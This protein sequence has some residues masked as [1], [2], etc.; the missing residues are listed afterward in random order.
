MDILLV[1]GNGRVA[2][3]IIDKLSKENH[4]IYVLTGTKEKEKKNKK[5]FEQYEFEYDN[6]CIKE[7]FVSVNPD[8]TI[9][10]G[11][12]DP[13]F[14]WKN[15]RSESTRYSTAIM[16]VLMAFSLLKH[17]RFI[18]LSSEE[19]YSSSYE[20][21]I[22]EAERGNA[23]SF[24][25]MAILQ[26]ENQCIDYS[27]MMG[28]DTMVLRIDNLCCMPEK[29]SDSFNLINKMCFDA[30][31]SGT[32]SANKNS[33]FSVIYLTDAVEAI[34]YAIIAKEHKKSLYNISSSEEIDEFSVAELISKQIK[35]EV[36]IVNNSIGEKHRIVLSNR[37]FVDEF[38]LQIHNS[39]EDIINKTLTYMKTN[40]K[41]Y[42]NESNSN[43]D[44]SKELVSKFSVI[45]NA[46]IP[47]ME[48][49]VCFIP[50]FML[51]N[52]AVGSQFFAKFDFYLL[53][54]LLFATIYGQ[55]QAAFSALLA[56]AGYCFR[57][58]YTRTS[59]EVV[60]DYNT[61][62]W[63]AQL[64]IV[65]LIVGYLRDKIKSIKNESQIE[66]NYLK[67]QMKDIEDINNSNIKIKNV[68][69][70]QIVN[71]HDSFG[72]IYDITSSLDKYEEG[73][74]LFYAAE[75][76]SKLMNSKDIA[77]Y[78]VANDDYARLI[79][80]TS[81]K[82]KQLGN[83]I[84]YTDFK[85]MYEA[86]MEKKVYINKRMDSIYPLMANAI[87][88]DDNKMKMI[89]MV[90]GIP[91]ER[92][93]LSQAN[94]F[95]VIGLLIRS[96]VIRSNKY[97]EA[98]KSTRYINGTKVLE[99]Q[100]FS[101]LAKTYFNARN[102][103]LTECAIIKVKCSQDDYIKHS[104]PIMKMLRQTDYMGSIDKKNLYV[105]LS[106]TNNE[107]A[108]YVINRFKNAGYESELLEE[109]VS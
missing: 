11:A 67:S 4:R 39:A 20:A 79:S 27:E 19:V 82:A 49:M 42:I 75:V 7:V 6:Q 90:W 63:I 100:A 78:I 72:K 30:F 10:L 109:I 84:K 36:N 89:F 101:D 80:S 32:I 28:R 5:V 45:I 17:G 47:F 26:G 96:A 105:L 52:R 77:I 48:N 102:K 43:I 98:F 23:V 18:Y 16:N 15:S 85:E 99:P 74:V 22:I 51:N 107:E 106:N 33:I 57:Q 61:Y 94:M 60:L 25:S 40:Y 73:E 70:T 95:K 34:Y 92:M 1:G 76:L 91:W 38:H 81:L 65:G 8:V 59:F 86:L 68:L 64:F 93:T 2:E 29:T 53:Y 37:E 9:F 12:Y 44:V 56:T 104:E 62:V 69:T 41:H 14:Q 103:G 54:V 83:S 55:Q 58:M 3:G 31:A 21:D 35:R 46:L 71:Q 108:E 24:K 87:Y 66:I 50:F 97:I 88:S 13:N